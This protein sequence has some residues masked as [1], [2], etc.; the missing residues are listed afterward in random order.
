MDSITTAAFALGGTIVGLFGSLVGTV[1]VPWLREKADLRRKD[2]A[3]I[4]ELIWQYNRQAWETYLFRE[5]K[6][7]SLKDQLDLQAIG[8]RLQSLL[9]GED[10]PIGRV[11]MQ[12][13][14]NITVDANKKGRITLASFELCATIW[15][16]GTADAA[17]ILKIYNHNLA[18]FKND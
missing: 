14:Q 13:T 2:R 1:L 10:E 3:V 18:T 15:L 11:I 17:S 16:N 8:F 7:R 4:R 9:Q 12:T 5:D 6:S